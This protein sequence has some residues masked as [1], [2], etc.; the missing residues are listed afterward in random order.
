MATLT[1]L[2][3]GRRRRD[4]DITQ[5]SGW[6]IP[7]AVF[8]VTATLSA[9]FLL[10]YLAPNPASLIE[11]S[12]SPTD[13]TEAVRLHVGPLNLDVPANY[14]IYRDARRGGERSDVALFAALPD[15]R[16]YSA[17]EARAFAD[18]AAGSPT[19]YIVIRRENFN[20]SERELLN[21]IYM[22]HVANRAGRR[23]PFGL[24][25]Y[26]FRDES[27]YGDE[28]LFVGHLAGRLVVMR[29]WHVSQSLPSPSC[30]RDMRLAKGAAVTYR[31]NRANLGQWRT[32]AGG[33]GRLIRRF[34]GAGA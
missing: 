25:Q 32:I 34:E 27:G 17:A 13:R 26:T 4:Q 33:V 22:N 3:P 18:D 21:R 9:L 6:L 30:L 1:R 29:C 7:L 31:F 5:H 10:F 23:G 24:T 11:D 2:S 14:I 28:D 8:V 12:P 20:L 15:F 19:I 16:G